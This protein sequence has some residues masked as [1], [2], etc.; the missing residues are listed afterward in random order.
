MFWWDDLDISSDMLS[1]LVKSFLHQTSR[2]AFGYFKAAFFF[3]LVWNEFYY[4]ESLILYKTSI[5]SIV[6]RGRR[7]PE[8]PLSLSSVL[9]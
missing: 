3:I 8:N 2:K 1:E 6:D 4:G 7:V 5:I 9:L